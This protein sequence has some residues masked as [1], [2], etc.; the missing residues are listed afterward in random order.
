MTVTE[1][2]VNVTDEAVFEQ[3]LGRFAESLTRGDYPEVADRFA[4]DGYWKD[5]LA[6]TWT[7][8]TFAGPSN[9]AD[10]F[11]AHGPTVQPRDF[12]LS[13]TFSA[14]R[15]AERFG[16]DVIEGFFDF[17]TEWGTS[18]G[19][20]RLLSGDVAELAEARA[21]M[22]LTSLN[23]LRGFEEKLGARRPDGLEYSRNFSGDNWLDKRIKAQ[24]YVDHDPEIIIIG[25]GQ[26]GLELA[27]ACGQIGLDAL[28]IEKNPRVGD[29]WRN[30]YKSL[31]LH[32]EVWSN[33]MLYMPF[34]DTWPTFV[35]KD[36]FAGWLE[37][38]AEAM[39]IAVWT[40]TEFIAASF[41]DAA[42]SWTV[43]VSKD[44]ERRTLRA[45]H[46]VLANGG[47]SGVP[48]VPHLP[49]LDAFEGE[50]THA[51]CFTTGDR[52][53]GRRAIVVGT[54]N[55]G[56]DVAQ[57]L[58]SNDANVTMLQR[59]PTCVVSLVPSALI[60]YSPYSEGLPVEEVDLMWAATP[61]PVLQDACQMITQM[62]CDLDKELVGG[63]NA[64]GFETDFGPDNTGFHMKYLR[65]GGGYYIN[66]GC[67]ELIADG[68]IKV[69]QERD[70]AKFVRDGLLMSDGTLM[71]ADVV[72]LATGFQNQQEGVRGFFGDDVADRVGAIWGFD[73][74]FEMR[75]MWKQTAQRGL[76]IAGGNLMDCRLR[77]R[78]LAMQ[79]KAAVEGF[80]PE[81][82]T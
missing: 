56:H 64:A 4:T 50:V 75:N 78:L 13:S 60:V 31:T 70:S 17:D 34:P 37:G 73:E 55:S 22:V 81:R 45:P 8:R 79:I 1:T 43:T 71:P 77:S 11:A 15:R 49:G 72:V 30:R 27:A 35:P 9:I 23:E 48:H 20:A 39:E 52:Y 6:F 32:N 53:R 33:H 80:L 36:K 66:V 3:W 58:Y 38:Y 59:G 47:T 40:S 24:T 12:R 69:V 68:S 67:S 51:S 18:T 10:G 29:N 19:F 61:Y 63:L 44:G 54:G 65:R 62:T 57:D 5:A 74:N 46:V 2:N 76:W 14:P 26:S 41:D 16:R 7:Y 82:T 28:V 25:A 42:S 21:W